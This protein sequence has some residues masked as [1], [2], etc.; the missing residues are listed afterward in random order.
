MEFL[1][2]IS[3]IIKCS[4]LLFQLPWAFISKKMRPSFGKYVMDAAIY[5]RLGTIVVVLAKRSHYFMVPFTTL[6]CPSLWVPTVQFAV[7]THIAAMQDHN[8]EI[9]KIVTSHLFL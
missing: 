4:K 7:F 5:L 8:R 9:R 3:I 6:H 1:W 2:T